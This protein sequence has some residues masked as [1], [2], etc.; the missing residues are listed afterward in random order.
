M[1]T[2]SCRLFRRIEGRATRTSPVHS[3]L[4]ARRRTAI[5]SA[6]QR[7]ARLVDL[8][9]TAIIVR[10]LDGR[11]TF[12]SAGAQSLYGWTAAEALGRITHDLLQTGFPA[13][14]DEIMADLGRRGNWSG[15]LRHRGSDGSSIIVESHWLAQAKDGLPA[16]IVEFN[17]DVTA[18]KQAEEAVRK[19]EDCHRQVAE[20]LQAIMEATP[21]GLLV[22]SDLK[23]QRITGNRKARE[24]LGVPPQQQQPAR[25]DPAT[26]AELSLQAAASTGIVV[27]GEEFEVP[28]PDG[29][30]RTM[31]MTAA[32]L[33][34]ADGPPRG[35]VGVATDI[36]N[37]KQ[38]AEALRESEQRANLAVETA[39]L[40]TYERDLLTN[41]IAMNPVC[42]QI[43][44][45][46][47][48]NPPQDIAPRSV[49]PDD[50][51]YVLGLV[52]RA[53]D[54]N[55]REVCAGEFRILRPDGSIRWVAGR[56]RVLF[57]DSADPPAPR[58]FVGVLSDITERKQAE[59]S[60]RAIRD[61]LARANSN[62]DRKVRERTAKLRE[63]IAEL[64]GFSYSL[65]HD[66]HAPLRAMLSYAEML[67]LTG[68]ALGTEQSEILRKIK[69][70][71]VRMDQLVTDSLNYSKLLRQDIR[72]GPVDLSALIHDL[73]ETYPNLH[74]SNTDISVEVT[75]VTVRGNPAALTQVFSNLLGN[76]VKFVAPG[77][78]PR[79][80][81]WCEP[82][83]T[84]SLHPGS[85]VLIW[86]EDNGIGIPKDQQKKIFGMFQ[87]LHRSGEYPGTGIGLALVRKSLD[88]IGG[89]I[90]L[91]SEP[92]RGSRFCV[93]LSLADPQPD[94]HPKV[95]GDPLSPSTA[96]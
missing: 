3:R 28:G 88:R 25:D 26:G 62:L 33:F 45:T 15:E 40:G 20:E 51:G 7:Q 78:H 84:D 16:E 1:N 18:R 36:P 44:G 81:V 75:D 71:A 39:A 85:H 80:R 77:V 21:V 69:V 76:A 34:A 64:E 49:H 61:E 12:W 89:A 30:R 5:A 72:L 93:R 2:F 66:M 65:V 47:D 58:K 35:A 94:P 55:L 19:S 96:S 82:S 37:D 95:V 14:L 83:V 50:A 31:A 91:D 59:E 4:S 56:G 6:L 43:L 46:D 53:Y 13:P 67:E 87:R 23:C 9:P 74:P 24:L 22:S 11:I 42:R 48:V 73:V 32:P 52:A 41:R 92:G 79:V 17:I 29:T 86:I 8:S 38:A 70:G 90:C 10:A 57:D 63:T 68:P 60:L 54:C 27:Q